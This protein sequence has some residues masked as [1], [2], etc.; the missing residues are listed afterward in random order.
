LSNPSWEKESLTRSAIFLEPCPLKRGNKTLDDL[1]D[2]HALK[3]FEAVARN[4]SFSRAAE[5]LFLSQP[6][7]SQQIKA[8]EEQLETKLFYRSHKEVILT[9]TGETLLKHAQNILASTGRLKELISQSRR[10]DP[11][12]LT[13]GLSHTASPIVLGQLLVELRARFPQTRLEIRVEPSQEITRRLADLSLDFAFVTGPANSSL[14]VQEKLCREPLLLVLAPGHPWANREKIAVKDLADQV[15]LFQEKGSGARTI[16]ETQL[17][18]ARVSPRL[19]LEI[20]DDGVLKR[21]VEDDLGV[22]FLPYHQV[23]KELSC[24]R[25]VSRTVQGLN[26]A[27]DINL[28]YHRDKIFRPLETHVI[29]RIFQSCTATSH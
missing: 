13:I 12:H 10:V 18:R 4:R 15:L 16:I 28:V 6:A 27:C 8:L 7:V 5:E 22:A 17:A 25:L 26:L 9:E 24:G 19:S 21:A 20:Q 2:L 11:L 23:E 1:I 29:S 3:V 14:L